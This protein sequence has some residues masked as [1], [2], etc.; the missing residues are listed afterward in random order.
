MNQS[1]FIE[2]LA[3]KVGMTKVKTKEFLDHFSELIMQEVKSGETVVLPLIGRFVVKHSAERT[4]RN[5]RTGHAMKVP[6]KKRMT[7]NPSTK[8]KELLA[9]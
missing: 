3:S 4:C 8:A 9:E 6:A 1:E 2:A 7:F 5:P